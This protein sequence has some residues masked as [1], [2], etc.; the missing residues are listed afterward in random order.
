[1]KINIGSNR[2]KVEG[3]TNVDILDLPEVDVKHDVTKIPWP[4]ADGAAHY[5]LMQE[6]LEHVGFRHTVPILQ[7]C[8]RVLAPGGVLCV[9]VPD[10]EAMCRM[11][12]LQC[13]CVPRKALNYDD[14][15][16]DP[17]CW[18]CGGKALIHPE[19]W[20][21]AFTGAQ[22]HEFDYHKNHFTPGYLEKC[23]NAAG[24]KNVERTP[25]VYKIII[26]ASK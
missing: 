23:F 15:K 12:D 9:Q 4:F 20:H 16:A 14:Y 18:N 25:N 11:I 8:H 13:A 26:K 10:I 24:F 5:I 2:K 17:A 3:F 1:M 19:R 6:F 7:E 22:K 21:V